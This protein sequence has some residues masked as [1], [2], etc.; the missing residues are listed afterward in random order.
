VE[1]CRAH[2]DVVLMAHN[3]TN[4]FLGRE[5]RRRGWRGDRLATLHNWGSVTFAAPRAFAER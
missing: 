2:G 4:R 5:L 3:F 1:A